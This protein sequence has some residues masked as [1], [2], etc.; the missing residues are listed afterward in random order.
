MKKKKTKTET[1]TKTKEIKKQCTS[2]PSV[3]YDA[4]ETRKKRKGKK[5][6]KRVKSWRCEQKA[7]DVLLESLS[8][9]PNMDIF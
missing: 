9:T 3:I 8:R 4:K 6:K 5:N 1:K 2:S 7:C